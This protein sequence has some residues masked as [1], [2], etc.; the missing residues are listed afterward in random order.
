M[1]NGSTQ[2]QNPFELRINGILIEKSDSVKYLGVTI[3]SKL[4]WR[5]HILHLEKKMST[6]CALISKT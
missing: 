2:T 3:D 6:A 1:I 4:T 5:Q